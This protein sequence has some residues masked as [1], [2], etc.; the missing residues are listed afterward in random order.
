MQTPKVL[1]LYYKYSHYTHL[2]LNNRNINLKYTRL[3]ADMSISI[4]SNFYDCGASGRRKFY[5]SPYLYLIMNHFGSGEYRFQQVAQVL[6]GAS[7]VHFLVGVS[8]R[9]VDVA[10]TCYMMYRGNSVI[11]NIITILIIIIL[12]ITILVVILLQAHSTKSE[13]AH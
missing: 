12:I 5:K 3:L 9:S 4:K 2:C 11:I 7:Q 8:P 10:L 13:M 6:V 1:L